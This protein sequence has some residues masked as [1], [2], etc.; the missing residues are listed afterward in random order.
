MVVVSVSLA[1][2]IGV[3]WWQDRRTAR[4]FSEHPVLDSKMEEG[5]E[6]VPEKER[7]EL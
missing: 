3:V 6:E 1:A 2:W 5:I 4:M 7:K